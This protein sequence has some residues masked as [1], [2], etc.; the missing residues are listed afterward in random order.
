MDSCHGHAPSQ[1]SCPAHPWLCH[2]PALSWTESAG[3][4][5]LA[6]LFVAAFDQACDVAMR[7]GG[8]VTLLSAKKLLLCKPLSEVM[9]G[10]VGCTRL[11][12][13]AQAAGPF[14]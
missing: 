5:S 7:T 4:M 3:Q 11:C 10:E 6:P 8:K 2:T 14:A 13:R 9:F 1:P 12:S